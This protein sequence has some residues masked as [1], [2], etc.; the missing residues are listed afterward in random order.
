MQIGM[1]ILCIFLIS[2]SAATIEIGSKWMPIYFS[3]MFV[4]VI[5]EQIIKAIKDKR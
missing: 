4:L 1:F 2:A 3:S 5:A